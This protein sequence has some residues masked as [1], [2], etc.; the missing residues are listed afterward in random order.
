[1]SLR[2]GSGSVHDEEMNAIIRLEDLTAIDQLRDF[3]SGTQAV[4]FSVLSGKDACY[5]WIQWELV[6]SAI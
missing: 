6:K 5:R 1:M 2:G 4:V 3:L